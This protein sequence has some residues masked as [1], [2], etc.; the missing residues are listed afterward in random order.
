M[1][2][3][4]ELIK[5]HE[6]T[7]ENAR[8]LVKPKGEDYSPNAETDTLE[9]LRKQHEFG[10]TKSNAHTAL[11]YVIAKASRVKSLLDKESKFGSLNGKVYEPNFESIEGSILDLINY[12]IYCFWFRY[13]ERNRKS[14]AENINW[15]ESGR[16][17][18]GPSEREIDVEDIRH[19][20]ESNTGKKVFTSEHDDS[21]Y[22]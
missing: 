16:I 6:A 21:S 3:S 17:K 12:A 18:F 1:V 4:E 7:C 14:E 20:Q 15:N 11:G 19:S 13:E 10:I 22:S 9:S 2:T 8:A 5:F